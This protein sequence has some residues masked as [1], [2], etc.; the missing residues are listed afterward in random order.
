MVIVVSNWTQLDNC[1]HDGSS[2]ERG[3]Q[4]HLSGK[5]VIRKH[6]IILLRAVKSDDCNS[7][8]IQLRAI[9]GETVTI[10][11]NKDVASCGG[12]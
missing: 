12:M 4:L 11:L 3:L 9:R 10:E 7:P 5:S 2:D 1:V 8:L 6:P